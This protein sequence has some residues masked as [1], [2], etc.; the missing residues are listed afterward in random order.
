MP[1]LEGS[2]DGTGLRVCVVVARWNEFVTRK[3]LEGAVSTLRERGLAEQDVTVAWVPGAF[4]VPTAAKWAAG[5][6][7]FDA[8]ICLGAVI[9]GETAHFEY[10]AG[11]AAEGIAA[12]SRETG[13][14]VM[15]GVLTVDSVDQALARAGGKDGHKGSESALAAIEMVNLR[16]MLA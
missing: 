7:K 12:V 3:L 9:R 4:E 15:F 2:T 11:G 14:P 1:E 13:V 8:V 6:G 16:R 10:V 5:S